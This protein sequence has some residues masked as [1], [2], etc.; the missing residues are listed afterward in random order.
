MEPQKVPCDAKTPGEKACEIY[1]NSLSVC[2]DLSL[3]V[4]FVGI[5]CVWREGME[6]RKCPG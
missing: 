3:I 2:H 5:N 1:S 6:Q 4:V